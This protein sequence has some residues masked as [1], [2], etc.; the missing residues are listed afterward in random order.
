MGDP[1]KKDSRFSKLGTDRKF[2]GVGRKQRK[3]KIDSRFQSLFTQEKFV[4]KCSVDKRGRPRHLS[5]KEDYAKFYDLDSSKEEDDEKEK[6][7]AKPS[8]KEEVGKKNRDNTS[9]E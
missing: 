8:K 9:E 4:S 7:K 1:I 6:V 2:R 3:V 5:A